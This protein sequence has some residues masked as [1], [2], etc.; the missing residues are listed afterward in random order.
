[1]YIL[2]DYFDKII[3]QANKRL[4]IITNGRY[5]LIRRNDLGKGNAQQG[6]DLDVYDI[7]TGK[8]RAAST[9]S[10]GE[11]FVTALSMALG[12]S[13]IIEEEHALVQVE[14][15]FID[16]GFG[17]LDSDY[18]DMAMKALETIRLDNKTIAIISHVEKLKEYVSDGLLVKKANTG[19]EIE[20]VENY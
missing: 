13:D 7:E 10:G 9:L 14:S 18:L 2:A 6:L 17:S 19:S 20:M 12:L 16:E 1:M 8:N 15:T 5:H 11:K 4:Q 3:T